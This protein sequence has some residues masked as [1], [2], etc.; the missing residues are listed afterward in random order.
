VLCL[1]REVVELGRVIRQIKE[2]L[3]AIGEMMDVFPAPIRN[4]AATIRRDATFEIFPRRLLAAQQREHVAAVHVRRRAARGAD[5]GGQQI[6][7]TNQI[8]AL[9]AGGHLPG[10][11]WANDER[12]MRRA[13]QPEGFAHQLMIAEEFAV[14]AGED[15]QRFAQQILVLQCGEHP[16]E[17]VIDLRDQPVV[18]RPHGPDEIGRVL[19]KAPGALIVVDHPRTPG[20]ITCPVANRGRGYGRVEIH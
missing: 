11:R 8:V 14:V 10:G 16:A 13:L 6:G 2:Q 20:R 5:E 9:L 1:P 12:Y 15:N 17:I 7:Q 4:G 18:R 3:R 19:V